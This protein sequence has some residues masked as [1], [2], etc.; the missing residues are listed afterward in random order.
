MKKGIII[1]L[2]VT[3]LATT[4]IAA[5]VAC[6]KDAADLSGYVAIDINPSI[7]FVTNK[8][9]KVQAV[10][11]ANGDAAVLLSD[12]NLIGMD[13]EDAVEKVTEASEKTGYLNSANNDVTV[14]VGANDQKA[15]DIL[16]DKAEQGV[17]KG[18]DVAVIAPD[19]AAKNLQAEVD[20]LKAAD[21][22]AYKKLTVAK[23]KL[24][25]SIAE[26]DPAFTPARA[27]EMR[28]NALVHMLHEY[29]DEYVDMVDDELEALFDQKVNEL[30]EAIYA[31]IDA[32]YG[33]E[34]AQKAPILRKLELLED[35]FEVALEKAAGIDKEDILDEIFDRDDDDDENEILT[36]EMIAELT[37]VIGEHNIT[38]LDRLD[39]YVEEL[40]D[41]LEDIEDATRLTAEQRAELTAAKA[42]LKQA[43]QQAREALKD[44][45]KEHI[46][47]LK[48]KKQQLMDAHR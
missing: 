24:A 16:T 5:L 29:I 38:T 45:V 7:E 21:P 40:E 4:A 30:A 19:D 44:V 34:Y 41:R 37:A 17:K 8:K 9:G 15:E 2:I 39:D 33:E 3:L 43:K 31:R 26:Y 42:E 11:A 46:E 14:T 22:E 10:R 32:L 27:A 13:I 28:T 48:A 47:V 6:N 12:M 23:L 20:A 35:K 36:A 18:S 25:R 1:S